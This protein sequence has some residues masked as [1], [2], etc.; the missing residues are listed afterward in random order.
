MLHYLYNLPALGFFICLVSHR[1]F[2]MLPAW[3][4]VQQLGRL[5]LLNLQ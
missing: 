4:E 1:D 3:Y 2:S 5:D